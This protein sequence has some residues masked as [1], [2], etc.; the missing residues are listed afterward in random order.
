MTASAM[1]DVITL[2]ESMVVLRPVDAIPVASAP[3][4]TAG[5]AG[6]ES[7]VAVGLSRLGHAVAFAG[8]VGDDAAGTRIRRTL[9]GEGIDVAGLR[10]DAAA[11]TGL[12][13]RDCGSPRG[14]SVDYH[15]HGSAGSRLQPSDL[16][17]VGIATA[18]VL[19]VTGLTCGLS[20]EAAA[21]VAAA[22]RIASDHDVTVVLDPNLR[23]RLQTPQ[24]WRELVDPLLQRCDVVLTSPDELATVI[25]DDTPERLAGRL[26]DRGVG[27]VVLRAGSAVTHAFDAD[28]HTSVEVEP[29][30]VVDPVG[31]GDAFTA[32][33]V[34]GMLDDLSMTDRIRRAHQVARRCVQSPGDIEGLP[35]RAEL[36]ADIEV[37]R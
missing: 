9:R 29:A 10:T 11:P 4:F 31:A 30:A 8:R 7:N 6:A 22:I 25:G 14:I 21:T 24:V 19:V 26:R 34:S 13:I 28:G 32:G 33:F 36:L 23:F 16:A 3:L 18:R 17:D 12:L 20:E 35:T 37:A 27:T 2:G 1:V 5:V 15:R